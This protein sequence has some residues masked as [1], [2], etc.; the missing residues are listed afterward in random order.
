MSKIVKITES[1]L[2]R[3]VKKIVNEREIDTFNEYMITLKHIYH[4]FNEETTEDEL[5][6]LINQIEYEIQTAEDDD[7]L[8][9]EELDEL[10]H[11]AQEIVDDMEIMF[12][13]K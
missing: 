10:I 4:E 8:S 12:Y 9:D 11:Y 3:L 2:V 6:F 5:D 7:E 1:D 13:E